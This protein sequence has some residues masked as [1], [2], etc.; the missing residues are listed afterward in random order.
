M[1]SA[2]ELKKRIA[3]ASILGI[4]V[5]KL[6]HGKEPCPIILFKVDESSEVGFY[7]TILFFSLAIHL[8]MQSV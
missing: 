6:C 3:S 2:V 7:R 8:R 5:G 1:I 4:I